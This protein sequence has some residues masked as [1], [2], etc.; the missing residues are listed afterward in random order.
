[1]P[2][3]KNIS[4]VA[5]IQGKL[6]KAHA[7][8]LAD[9]RGLTVAEL[10]ELRRALRAQQ[11]EM[12]VYKNRLVRQALKGTVEGLDGQLTGPTAVTFSYGDPVA[13]AKILATFAKA[14]A[15]LQLKG[16]L[17][18]GEVVDKLKVT[19]L[20]ALPSRE[21]LLT[22]LVFVLNSPIT[23]LVRVLN[24]TLQGLPNVLNRIKEK[25]A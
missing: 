14:H 2:N 17:V 9:Y 24:G 15:K 20:A 22:K 6:A 12:K 8:I 7:V 13:P 1:M 16:G 25:K 10:T 18:E 23:G 4:Q 11:M 19:Q 21:E 3:A 5:E